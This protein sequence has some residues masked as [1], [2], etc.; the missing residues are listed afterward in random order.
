MA[1]HTDGAHTGTTTA[2]RN[3]EG[4]VQV[5]VTNVS[6]N[7]S[8][9]GKAHLCVHV[10]TIH[11][12][13]SAMGVD[14]FAEFFYAFFKHAISTWV[15][16]ADGNQTSKLTLRT[17]IRLQPAMVETRDSGEIIA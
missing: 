4:F 12:Y 7:F 16:I 11:I 3:S 6:A 1:L 17:A 13:L 2:V 8:W 10:G 14:D 5:Q 15:I 9:R